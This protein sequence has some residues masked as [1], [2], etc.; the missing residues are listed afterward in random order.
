MVAEKI[1]AKEGSLEDKTLYFSQIVKQ[2]K[3]GVID[4]K[5]LEEQHELQK[6][7]KSQVTKKKKR[8]TKTIIPKGFLPS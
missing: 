7:E 8:R 4:I 6:Q 5:E 2:I 1:I 3:D